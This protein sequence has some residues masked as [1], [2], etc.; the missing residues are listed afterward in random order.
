MA[1]DGDELILIHQRN[2]DAPT[3]VPQVGQA[4][5]RHIAETIYPE[6][7]VF[8]GEGAEG[9]GSVLA[10]HDHDLVIYVENAGEFKV[11]RSAIRAVHDRKVVL[12]AEGLDKALLKAIGH[13]HDREDPEVA[14]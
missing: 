10:V 5:T 13:R 9:V 2:P 3:D 1:A 12:A 7:M 11:A 4:G 14:G 8:I 6:Y